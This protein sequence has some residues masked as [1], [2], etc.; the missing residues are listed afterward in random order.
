MRIPSSFRARTFAVLL[1]VSLVP[2]FLALAA[3]TFVLRELVLST[4]SAGAWGEVAESGQN[5]FEDI[6]SLGTAAQP[7]GNSVERHR[8]A[9]AESVRFSRLYAFLADR[10]LTLLPAFALVLMLL[11]GGLALA[12]ANWFSA[13]FSRPVETLV[14]WTRALADGTALDA[15]ERLPTRGEIA[16]FTHLQDALKATSVQLAMARRRELAETRVRSWSQM[17][18]KIAHDL[19]NPLT[20]MAMAARRVVRS[21][22]PAVS[23]AGMVLTEEI[24]RLEALA[25]AFAH[26]GTPPE[27]E[28]SPVDVTELLETVTSRSSSLRFP[29]ELDAAP[30]KVLVRGHLEALERV[31]RNLVSNAVEATEAVAEC[32]E[33]GEG[34][35]REPV[36]IELRTGRAA[37][38]IAIL[39]RG[40]GIPE[41]TLERIWEPEFTSKRTGTGLGLAIVRQ[42][43]GA[44]GGEIAAANRP[45]G[46]ARFVVRLPLDRATGAG[47]DAAAGTSSP[48]HERDAADLPAGPPRAGD[49]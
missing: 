40:V 9:L 8:T 19:R 15:R 31:F 41:T 12:A 28:M 2:T 7:L 38:E 5:L 20:P 43:I 48:P 14:E 44:H 21:K 42:V 10:T 49:P 26:F 11:A 32:D 46:G 45:D 22:E 6:A 34:P 39:D 47:G 33:G 29:V 17:A 24:A 27:G 18:R 37:A 4:G 25:R 36:R 13:G 1:L 3:G 30:D 35:V 23:E 16:E